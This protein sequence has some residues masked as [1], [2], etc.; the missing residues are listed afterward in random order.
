MSGASGIEPLNVDC[1]PD[2]VP[3]RD[4]LLQYGLLTPVSILM[5]QERG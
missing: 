4:S 3:E 2:L 5:Q 1:R